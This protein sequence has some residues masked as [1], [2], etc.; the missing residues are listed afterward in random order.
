MHV[1]LSKRNSSAR[2]RKCAPSALAE[3]VVTVCESLH[4]QCGRKIPEKHDK[5][6]LMQLPLHRLQKKETY[7]KTRLIKGSI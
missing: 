5:Y 4:I 3:L 1:D 7:I 6:G 2:T